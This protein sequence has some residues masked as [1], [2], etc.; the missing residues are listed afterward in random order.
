[1]L[2]L[3]GGEEIADSLKASAQIGDSVEHGAVQI[4]DS[5][6]QFIA[7][8]GTKHHPL[9]PSPFLPAPSNADVD[10]QPIESRRRDVRVP[11]TMT[12]PRPGYHSKVSKYNVVDATPF[13]RDPMKELAE[14]CKKHDIKLCFYYSQAQ[15]WH[16]PNGAGN[17]W[18]FPPNEEKVFDQYLRD[19]SLPQVE[20]LLRNYGPIGLIWFDT[21]RLMTR[22]HANQFSKLVRSIQPSTLINSRLGPGDDIDYRSMGDN[23]IP[24]TVLEGAWETAATVN[25]TWGYKE[26]D[27]NWKSP[28]DITFKLVDIVSKGGNY[29]LN[30]G[31]TADGVI[32][33]PSQEI[34]RRVGRWLKVNGEAVYG[35]GR[36]PFGEELGSPIPGKKDRRGQQAYDVK[37]DWRCTTQPGRL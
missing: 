3:A 25:D 10:H 27:H 17:H 33:E 18:D 1:M 19:K 2:A 13:R 11:E 6:R 29:L 7:F 15:D 37:K 32:P 34:L 16:E 26:D 35:A 9:G 24:H 12:L 36:T 31:P 23:Q 20:E 8:L 4:R 14:A 30:V 21:P 22:E 5:A 28:A